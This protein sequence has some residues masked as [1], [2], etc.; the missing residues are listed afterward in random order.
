M[1]IPVRTLSREDAEILARTTLPRIASNGYVE[2]H[3][4]RWR[5]DA[6]RTW[7]IQQRSLGRKP[8]VTVRIDELDLSVVYVELLDGSQKTLKAISTQQKYTHLLS[9][10]EHKKLKE[11]MKELRL[12]DRLSQMADEQAFNLRVEYYAALGRASDPIA[13]RRLIG[14]RD[15]L[16]I[17]RCKETDLPNEKGT[18]VGPE[19]KA[20]PRQPRMRRKKPP[21]QDDHTYPTSTESEPI[22]APLLPAQPPETQSV[23][24][25]VQPPRLFIKRKP[26]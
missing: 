9:L 22:A 19:G 24:P 15:Q 18:P 3:D 11:K 6:L 2:C 23:E 5:S 17:L 25:T 20:P 4:L 13:Y 8:E 21:L 14:L 16:A 26:L 1:S 12:K 7:E 10:Y